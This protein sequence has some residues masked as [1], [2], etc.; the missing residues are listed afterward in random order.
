MR[1]STSGMTRYMAMSLDE[2]PCGSAAHWASER[3]DWMSWI[4][5]ASVPA[6]GLD[7]WSRSAMPR[8]KAVRLKM[9]DGEKAASASWTKRV[10][11]ASLREETSN[12]TGARLRASSAA[13]SASSVAVPA[14]SRAAR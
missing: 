6:K 9:A 8:A 1:P 5:G 11:A 3:P 14:P 4:T 10:Q 13:M 7:L 2:R 12:G